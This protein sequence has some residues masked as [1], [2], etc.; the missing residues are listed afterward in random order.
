ME[1][2]LLLFQVK[3]N[4]NFIFMKLY[5]NTAYRLESHTGILCKLWVPDERSGRGP[6]VYNIRVGTRYN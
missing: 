6:L 2:Y 1:Q 3:T 4:N 5:C